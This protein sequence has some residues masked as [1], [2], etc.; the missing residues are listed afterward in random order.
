MPW[1]PPDAPTWSPDGRQIAFTGTYKRAGA[2]IYVVNVD[3]TGLARLTSPRPKI[4]D[5]APAWSPDGTQIV[6][7]RDNY[8]EPA[9]SRWSS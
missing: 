3:G 2:A 5:V 4:E 6:F 9:V 7:E 8:A 1:L